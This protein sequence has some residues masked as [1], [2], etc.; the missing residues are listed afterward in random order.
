MHAFYI[1][2]TFC[3]GQH[4]RV[5]QRDDGQVLED[6]VERLCEGRVEATGR[7]RPLQLGQRRYGRRN[8][9]DKLRLVSK[10]GVKFNPFVYCTCSSACFVLSSIRLVTVLVFVTD[11]MFLVS[12]RRLSNANCGWI[13]ATSACQSLPL[14]IGACM[15][16]PN[17]PLKLFACVIVV[18]CTHSAFN[19]IG[20]RAPLNEDPQMCPVHIRR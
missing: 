10:C 15:Y 17:S 13:Q 12:P 14:S 5:Q 18:R 16:A 20:C 8:L 9:K 1:I 7:Q 11:I 2:R 6:V 4:A 3:K 19:F